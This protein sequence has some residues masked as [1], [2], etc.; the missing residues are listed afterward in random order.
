MKLRVLPQAEAEA[1]EAACW[2]DDRQAGLGEDFLDLYSER[3]REIEDQPDRFPLLE[4]VAKNQRIRRCRLPRFPYQI[5][6][7]ILQHEVLV[8]AVMHGHR[9]PNYWMRRRRPS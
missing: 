4:T 3:L 1:N 9:R 6:Y 7:E 2:Y 5:V 8:L